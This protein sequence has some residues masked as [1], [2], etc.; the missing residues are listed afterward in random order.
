MYSKT[1]IDPVVSFRNSQ[2]E[3][4]RG[5]IINL[6][7][8]SL[9]ME[10]YNPYS[11]VQVSEVLSDLYDSPVD[12]IR[13]R[14]RIVVVGTSDAPGAHPDGPHAHHDEHHDPHHDEHDVFE[15][16]GR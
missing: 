10:I 15:E 16:V 9:V 4:V 8:N 1:Q 12:V 5:T 3:Q 13:T 6:Q 14:G 11:I 7:R 2:G